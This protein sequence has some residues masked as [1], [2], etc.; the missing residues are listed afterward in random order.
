MPYIAFGPP[1]QATTLVSELTTVKLRRAF[2]QIR[3][4]GAVS[5]SLIRSGRSRST[6]AL[7]VLFDG[8]VD[9]N[10]KRKV[11]F[12]PLLGQS[13][14]QTLTQYFLNATPAVPP[15]GSLRLPSVNQLLNKNFVAQGFN[16]SQHHTRGDQIVIQFVVNGQK[17]NGLKPIFSA[18]RMDLPLG[19]PHDLVKEGAAIS[20][21]DPV[22]DTTNGVETMSGS[23]FINPGDTINL[24][25]G[26][27]EFLYDFKLSDGLGRTYT[28]ERGK[29]KIS[30]HC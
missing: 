4:Q 9:V 15:A 23:F 10:L 21:T 7:K 13:S 24:P 11:R 12:S 5:T 2:R 8:K 20:M 1:T 22:R 6:G 19:S 27:L 30:S 28:L 16:G 3:A 29:F 25:D 26:S 17:M 18:C 14:L